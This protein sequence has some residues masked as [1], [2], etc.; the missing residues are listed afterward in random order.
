VPVNEFAAG[1]FTIGYM[2]VDFEDGAEPSAQPALR[3][4][5]EVVKS[6]GVKLKEIKLPEFPYGALVGTIIA[7]EAGS[8][9]EDLIRSGRVD[10]LADKHQIA[11][12]KAMLDLPAIEYQRAMRVRTL[13]PAVRTSVASRESG[14]HS[15]SS[16]WTSARRGSSTGRRASMICSLVVAGM[17][18]LS[19]IGR[20]KLDAANYHYAD[21]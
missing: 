1:R 20:G 7:G 19:R 16:G 15:P 9:F 14:R 18:T 21:R 13:W 3:T 2:P 5:F 11:G 10:Q 4:A 17:V 6:L 12:L 8:I